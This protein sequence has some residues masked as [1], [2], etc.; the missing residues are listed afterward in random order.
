MD[1]K[2]EA[3]DVD[4]IT[5]TYSLSGASDF[6]IDA[7]GPTAG[8]ISVAPRRHARP[9]GHARP[10]T[11]TVTA[12]DRLNESDSITVTINVSTT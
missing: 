6:V 3:T 2:V 11:V 9:R 1:T 10:T 8:Q 12:T 5:L 7:S 4:D